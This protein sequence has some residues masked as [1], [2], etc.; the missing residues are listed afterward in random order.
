M[1]KQSVY[2]HSVRVPLVF[3]GPGI[4]RGEEREA[5]CY[6]SDIY[7]TLCELIGL[8]IPDSV[9]GE[10]LAPAIRTGAERRD[11][12]YFAY[13]HLHR[14]VRDTRYKL[15][16]Y[17]VE[18]ERTTRLFDLEADAG[19]RNDLAH[20]PSHADHVA[21]LRSHLLAWRADLDDTR[22]KEAAFWEGYLRDESS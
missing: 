11:T 13:E 20:D 19:E 3:A 8:P 10:S 14:A 1:G 17:V 18:G 2:E 22:E 7:P 9:E 5:L 6:L 4:P 21:R 16:E 12:L 15:I